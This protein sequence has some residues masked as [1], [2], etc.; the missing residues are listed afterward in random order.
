MVR[1]RD[2]IR[3]PAWNLRAY[4]MSFQEEHRTIVVAF[5]ARSVEQAQ[6]AM[7]VHLVSSSQRYRTLAP[8]QATTLK[9]SWLL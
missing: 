9:P 6:A 8:D 4:L 7:R 2:N 5:D 3:I 1:P